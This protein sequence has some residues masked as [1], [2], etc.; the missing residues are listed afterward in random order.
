MDVLPR[1]RGSAV[2]H[3]TTTSLHDIVPDRRS[4][5]DQERHEHRRWVRTFLAFLVSLLGTVAGIETD[6]AAERSLGETISVTAQQIGTK[7]EGGVKKVVKKVEDKHIV[8]KVE[9][10]LAK[11]AQKTAEGLEKAGKNIKQKLAD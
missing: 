1:I 10:N 5:M 4:S 6:S 7:I 9:R 8:D 11:A 3:E 2:F